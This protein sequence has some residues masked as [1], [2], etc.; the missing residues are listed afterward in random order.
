MGRILKRETRSPSAPSG[1]GRLG[2]VSHC[3]RVKK[4]GV[5]TVEVF[6]ELGDDEHPETVTAELLS[7]PGVDAL[8]LPGDEVVI[9]ETEGSGDTIA[10]A[11]ADIINEGKAADG[12][13]RTYARDAAG[14]VAC[15]IWCKADGTVAVKSIKDGSKLNLNGVLI[16]QQGNITTPGDVK[17]MAGTPD[18]PQPGV[19]LS[20]H[21]HPT[22]VGP[23]SA[24][25]PG[26]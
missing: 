5:P 22:G 23:T 14:A 8:P 9:E 3:E 7:A 24:P 26:T 21:L 11:F 1:S 19:K 6:V 15:E 10:Q 20:T 18:A 12:E 25:T 16:D 17:A 4:N 13:H 2:K